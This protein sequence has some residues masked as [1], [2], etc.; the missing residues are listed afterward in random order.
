MIIGPKKYGL[1]SSL[2]LNLDTT[3]HLQSAGHFNAII[4]RETKILS[5]G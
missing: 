2:Q 3:R 5:E 1:N 4:V